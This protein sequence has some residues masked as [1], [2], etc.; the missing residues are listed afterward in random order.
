MRRCS[1]APPWF[2]VLVA[3]VLAVALRGLA[4]P[5]ELGSA[6]GG[7]GPAPQLAFWALFASIASWIWKGL[8]LIGQVT[9]QAL[10]VLVN[11]LYAFTLSLWNTL[12]ALGVTVLRGAKWLWDFF[13]ITYEFVLKPAVT[14]LWQFVRWAQGAL[15]ELFGPVIKF[16]KFL[17]KWVLD[18]YS[19]YVRPILDL[20]GI[21]RKVLDILKVFGIEWAKALDRKLAE[22]ESRID[23]PFRYI[24]AELNKVL[25]LINRIVTADGLFQ[26]LALLGSLERD[27]RQWSSMWWRRQAR[28]L[29]PAEIARGEAAK[30]RKTPEEHATEFEEGLLNGTGRAAGLAEEEAA[31]LAALLATIQWRR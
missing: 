6:G 21:V 9:L 22:L 27:F 10:A 16:V 11:Y 15:E 19:Q 26:R 30:K 14:K 23:A 17:R 18:F 3:A 8:Q 29:T 7:D 1:P 5:I 25:G 24:I 28:D 13:Q 4:P 31:A 12:R 2:V 20:I